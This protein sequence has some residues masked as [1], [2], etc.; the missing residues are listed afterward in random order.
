MLY[1]PVLITQASGKIGDAVAS[2][3]RGT[4]YFRSVGPAP[5]APTAKQQNLQFAM[6]DAN[7]NWQAADPA[8]RDEWAY[9]AARRDRPDRI[10]RHFPRTGWNEFARWAVPRGQANYEYTTSLTTNADVPTTLDHPQDRQLSLEFRASTQVFVYFDD[11]AAWTT[12]PQATPHLLIRHHPPDPQPGLRGLQPAAPDHRRWND[13][14]RLR[15]RPRT[16]RIVG[17]GRTP[18]LACPDQHAHQR[19]QH[20]AV[21]PRHFRVAQG[22]TAMS[23]RRRATRHAALAA[24]TAAVLYALY[25]LFLSGCAVDDRS[26]G[27][28]MDVRAYRSPNVPTTT[29]PDPTTPSGGQPDNR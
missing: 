13:A 11:T 15:T 20:P 6:M 27:M 7:T 9:F 2:R 21:W 1:K 16:A 22:A 10:G 12:D 4:E 25:N 26:W 18:L 28:S 3:N 29:C 5:G 8:Y 24:F 19:Q 14:P 23:R 17:L